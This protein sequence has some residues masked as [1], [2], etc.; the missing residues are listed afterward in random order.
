M[1]EET[2]VAEEKP[3]I[4]VSPFM[5]AVE[6]EDEVV[7]VD[8]ARNSKRSCAIYLLMKSSQSKSHPKRLVVEEKG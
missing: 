3:A 4:E 5:M 6:V 2:P 7:V 8:D 1:L